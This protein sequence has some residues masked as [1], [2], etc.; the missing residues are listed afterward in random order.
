MVPG[1]KS[2]GAETDQQIHMEAD[3]MLSALRR[4]CWRSSAVWKDDCVSVRLHSFE[5][6]LL[7]RKKVSFS[8]SLGLIFLVLSIIQEE[9]ESELQSDLCVRFTYCKVL[10]VISFQAAGIEL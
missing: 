7:W 8:H 1:D 3:G 5:K 10:Q 2:T 4:P 9:S 6:E